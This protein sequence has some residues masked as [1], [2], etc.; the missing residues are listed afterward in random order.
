M[1][2][3]LKRRQELFLE[4]IETSLGMSNI[5][6][7]RLNQ[8]LIELS[9]N[10][11]KN[12]TLEIQNLVFLDSWSF[13]DVINRLRIFILQIPGLK[14]NSPV[15][16]FLKSSEQIE[17]LRNFVQHLDNEIPNVVKSGFPI[18]GSLSWL[19]QSQEIGKLNRLEVKA[20][21]PRH[22]AGA[23]GHQIVN[24]AGKTM[25][26]TVDY[27]SLTASNITINLSDI[28]Q[29]TILFE[30]QFNNAMAEIRNT[31]QK[32]M[33]VNGIFQITLINTN[34]DKKG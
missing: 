3:N 16:S 25:H 32:V 33:E 14:K 21:I 4:G 7:S 13:V 11:L 2:N 28:Y 9:K 6:Y 12:L 20:I 30:K 23:D 24:L 15:K 34:L 27:I 26:S 17:T 18:W 8:A 22:L 10:D 19:Y 5:C 1:K 31:K 29:S